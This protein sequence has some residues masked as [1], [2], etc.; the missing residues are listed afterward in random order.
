MLSTGSEQQGQNIRVRPGPVFLT[1]TKSLDLL[2]CFHQVCKRTLSTT[3]MDQM[4]VHVKGYVRKK[5]LCNFY[6][7]QG[8]SYKTQLHYSRPLDIYKKNIYS[9]KRAGTSYSVSRN[10]SKAHAYVN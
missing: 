6:K 5:R 7:F 2:V 10:S 1:L 4:V 8:K 9:E 3:T